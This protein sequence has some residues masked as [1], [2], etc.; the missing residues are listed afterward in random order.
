MRSTGRVKVIFIGRN[1]NLV[2]QARTWSACDL[3]LNRIYLWIDCSLMIIQCVVRYLTCRIKEHRRCITLLAMHIILYSK[4]NAFKQRNTHI[5]NTKCMPLA[6]LWMCSYQAACSEQSFL[7]AKQKP[8]NHREAAAFLY[9]SIWYVIQ[10][11]DT[12]FCN[13]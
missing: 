3:W 2:N 9:S 11:G 5:P 1:K 10:I 6:R 4:T 8:M 13:N 12:V 7:K